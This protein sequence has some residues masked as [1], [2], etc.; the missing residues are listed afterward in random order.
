MSAAP[1]P[2][3]VSDQMPGRSAPGRFQ[4]HAEETRKNLKKAE[5][6]N[7][8]SPAKHW[9]SDLWRRPEKVSPP[10]LKVPD[11]SAQESNGP[12]PLRV[13]SQ[14][15]PN[16]IEQIR[17]RSNAK[18][19]DLPSTAGIRCQPVEK[20]PG[21][22]VRHPPPAGAAATRSPDPRRSRRRPPGATSPTSSSPATRPAR[23]G[24]PPRSTA[25]H[26]RLAHP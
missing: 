19:H 26:D 2:I 15:Q 14:P 21:P 23:S 4:V 13:Q 10:N 18:S 25:R 5:S 8:R 6:Q 12:C 24:C 3:P 22:N 11:H 17:T 7:P 1:M 20:R 16:T 9:T